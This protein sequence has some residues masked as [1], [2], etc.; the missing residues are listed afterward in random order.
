[1]SVKERDPYTGHMI[2]G[3]VW[4][5]IKELNSPVPMLWYACFFLAFVFSVGYWIYM[6]AWPSV[7][8][9]TQGVSGFDQRDELAR[10]VVKANQ[11]TDAWRQIIVGQPLID[12]AADADIMALVERAGPALFEDNCAGCH[13]ETGEGAINFPQLN[14]A[15]WLWG[16]EPEGIYQTLKYGINSGHPQSRIA[17]MP[18]FGQTGQL[19][20]TQ[21]RDVSLYLL[22][23]S[24][25]VGDGSRSSELKSVHSGER[26]FKAQCFACHG[27]DAMGNPLLGAPN[28]VDTEWTYGSSLSQ[29]NQTISAGRAGYMPAWIDRIDD[30]KLRILSLYVP[31]LSQSALDHE[32]TNPK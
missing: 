20:A 6:P 11:A 19:D 2:T 1:M 29:L 18:A 23:L 28:L 16:A 22:S 9:H 12:S 27:A 3:H 26:I 21:I 8:S 31:T 32:T 10:Q 5:G 4:N 15:S 30:D 25:S 13:G 24:S 14:D 17:Q 7:R